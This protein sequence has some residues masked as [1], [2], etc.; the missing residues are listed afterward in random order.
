M[1]LT[2]RSLSQSPWQSDPA[3][4]AVPDGRH[5]AGRMAAHATSTWP[6]DRLWLA[7]G[8]VAVVYTA[9]IEKVALAPA[10]VLL[11]GG[12][13]YG[14]CRLLFRGSAGAEQRSGYVQMFCAGLLAVAIARTMAVFFDDQL[15]NASDAHSFFE[16]AALILRET[17]I[18]EV[19]K[20]INGW[21]AVWVW[22][23]AYQFAGYFMAEPTPL[24]G[25]AVNCLILALGG[26]LLVDAAKNLRLLA[27]TGPRTAKR[28]YVWCFVLWLFASFHLRDGMTVFVT[29]LTLRLWVWLYGRPTAARLVMTGFGSTALFWAISTL[30]TESAGIVVAIAVSGLVGLVARTRGPAGII[31]ALVGVLLLLAAYQVVLVRLLGVVDVL[32]YY[33]E[34]YQFDAGEQ[35]LGDRYILRANPFVRTVLGVAYLHVFPVPIWSGYDFGSAYY[36]FKSAQLAYLVILVA[37]AVAGAWRLWRAGAAQRGVVILLAGTY[38][39]ITWAVGMSSLETRH[40]A[41]VLPCLMLLGAC[42]GSPPLEQRLRVIYVAGLGAVHVLWVILKFF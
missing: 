16:A 38:V 11:L 20:V 12:L 18:Y 8:A 27:E 9:L 28:L 21:G 37:A 15:Q 4:A 31:L 33:R 7:A 42:S 25:L 14:L 3:G 24:V 5:P 13:G 19:Q 29:V 6:A 32:F 35:S 10:W 26:A 1:R 23:Q 22:A 40:Y 30:R 17:D 36:W 39:V 34:G 2:A 41:Q